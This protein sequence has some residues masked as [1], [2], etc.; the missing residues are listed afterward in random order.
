MLIEGIQVLTKRPAHEFRLRSH[1]CQRGGGKGDRDALTTWGMI[2]MLD[3][4]ESRV[5]DSV[6]TPSKTTTPS[7][8]MQ[9]S[10]ANVRL[11]FPAPVRPTASA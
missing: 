2:V 6:G 1:S 5:M 11:D 4:N 10:K 7:V 9:R 8:G 3:R